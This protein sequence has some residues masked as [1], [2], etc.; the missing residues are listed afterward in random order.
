M[1]LRRLNDDQKVYQF[2]G[3]L[4]D[5]ETL[6]QRDLWCPELWDEL[7]EKANALATC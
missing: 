4:K 6:L 3:S 5:I 2:M 1:T 7:V